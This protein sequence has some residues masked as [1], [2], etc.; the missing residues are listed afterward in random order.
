MGEGIE[1][2]YVPVLG[3]TTQLERNWEVV[4]LVSR[5]GNDE[6]EAYAMTR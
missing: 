3:S 4:R 6:G 2:L 1:A 5:G